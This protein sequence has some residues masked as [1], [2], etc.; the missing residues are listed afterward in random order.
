MV[1]LVVSNG[2]QLAIDRGQKPPKRWPVTL[3]QDMQCLLPMCHV[4]LLRADNHLVG[5]LHD[6]RGRVAP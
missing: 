1:P 3:K 6:H 2:R 4:D 5:I